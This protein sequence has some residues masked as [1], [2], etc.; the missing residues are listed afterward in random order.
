MSV[1]LSNDLASVGSS[2]ACGRIE[3]SV[4]PATDW[5]R[6]APWWTELSRSSPYSSAF[7][8]THWTGAWLEAF[9]DLLPVEILVFDA[10]GS[11]V[12]ACLLVASSERRGPFRVRRIYLNTSGGPAADRST[13]EFNNLVCRP[14]FEQKIAQA[15][16]A[17]L[18]SRQW[19]EF[20]IEGICPGPLLSWLQTDSFSEF[21]ASITTLA[22]SYVD[23]DRLRRSGLPYESS[24]SA[25]TR[26]QLHRSLRL[27][28]K[29]GRVRVELARDLPTAER[30]FAEMCRM[31]QNTWQ[32][33]GEP[34]AF[35]S[36]RK[37]AFHRALIRGAFVDGAIQMLRVTAAEETIGILYNF[38]EKD[39]VYFYQSGFQYQ[40][41]K[42]LK[43][44]LVTHV[45][46]IRFCLE[47]GYS[48]YD[49]LVGEARYKK[50][51]AKD[52]RPLAWVVFSRPSVKLAL[53]ELLRTM[54]ARITR[55][56]RTAVR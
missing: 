13:M 29:R 34:G 35:A 51:L 1:S 32:G 55:Y 42:R 54:K 40:P 31:H 2:A 47:A 15:L 5:P 30:F 52:A 14:G 49:F 11:A 56:T 6:V 43:P 41:D 26:E 21:P 28:E 22:S 33:R 17:H 7:L 44:G 50:S 16:G 38:V 9:A 8:S 46:A 36:T 45:C 3:V 10:G 12:G 48:D 53:I 19:E 18:R 25:N 24:I 37:L 23:L 39:K 4:Y 27:Y 20:A